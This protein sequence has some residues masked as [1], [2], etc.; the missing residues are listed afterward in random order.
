MFKCR[1]RAAASCAGLFRA[2]RMIARI[3]SGRTDWPQPGLAFIQV[4][5]AHGSSPCGD[6]DDKPEDDDDD[7]RY[8]GPGL[9]GRVGI[10]GLSTAPAIPSTAR[11]GRTC[12]GSPRRGR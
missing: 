11:A 8:R 2:W 6:D 10:R 9:S 1:V 5:S 3:A 7:K 12:G 4:S